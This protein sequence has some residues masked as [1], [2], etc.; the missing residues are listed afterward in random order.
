MKKSAPATTVAGEL[1]TGNLQDDM[2]R[3]MTAAQAGEKAAAHRIFQS[4]ATRYPDNTEIWVWLGGTSDDLDEAENAFQRAVV[5]EPTNE[6]A[7]LGLRWVALRRQILQTIGAGAAAAAATDTSVISTGRIERST[8][9]FDLTTGAFD[10]TV[11]AATGPLGTGYLTTATNSTNGTG[12][13]TGPLKASDADASVKMKVDGKGAGTRRRVP[14]GA[15]ILIVVALLLY[16]FAAYM[17]F[18][19]K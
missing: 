15:I 9:T 7:N 2:S 19:P 5:L 3:A 12:S 14:V 11:P 13:L 16:A 4:L 18:G 10:N 17:Y 1:N 6:E 8:T